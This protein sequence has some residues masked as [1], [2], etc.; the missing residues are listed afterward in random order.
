MNKQS[1]QRSNLLIKTFAKTIL[2][3]LGWNSVFDSSGIGKKS[4]TIVIYPHTSSF[5]YII[6]LLYLLCV[7]E[8][9]K[10]TWTLM[11][12]QVFNI[13][14]LGWILTK[15]HCIPC[16][17]N[18]NRGSNF[19]NKITEMF[20]DNDNFKLM[21]SPKGTTARSQWR[22]GYYHLAKNLNCDVVIY[23]LDYE[24]KSLEFSG[25]HK[26][27]DHCEEKEFTSKMKSIF[28]MTPQMN[29]ENE[30]GQSEVF[31]YLDPVQLLPFDPVLI[32]NNLMLILCTL[33]VS[34]ISTIGLII[35]IPGACLSFM[36]HLSR[37]TLYAELEGMACKMTVVCLT[38]IFY[39]LQK[40]KFDLLELI[41]SL[42]CT[43]LYSKGCG[44]G[45]SGKRSSDYIFYHS[46]FHIAMITM[47]FKI[48][49]N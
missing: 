43:Y 19:V 22:K 25:R 24:K 34:M 39:Q 3:F 30:E 17:K 46:L 9:F 14:P 41:I 1:N 36:Y 27:D 10:T 21:I 45:V 49:L 47:M 8:H 28:V 29:L 44:R 15:L 42:G 48:Y 40:L 11:K 38:F 37:E 32:T 23:A 16:S 7:P 33:L 2:T 4:K 20:K 31:N 5:D 12:P 13:F 18:E 6:V 26:I 35:V